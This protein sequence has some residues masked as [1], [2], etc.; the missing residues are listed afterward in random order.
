[1]VFL[2]FR[3]DISMGKIEL[4]KTNEQKRVEHIGCVYLNEK[5]KND[6]SNVDRII[7]YYLIFDHINELLQII[8]KEDLIWLPDLNGDCGCQ[9]GD[10][11][12]EKLQKQ[13]IM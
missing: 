1:M 8:S 6:I 3:K 9:K 12:W 4:G 7:G 11:L 5:E 2:N 13:T 10:Y